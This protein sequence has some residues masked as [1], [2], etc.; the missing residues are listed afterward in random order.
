MLASAYWLLSAAGLVTIL[1]QAG[2]TLVLW[3]FAG[4]RVS[5]PGAHIRIRPT[6]NFNVGLLRNPYLL[7][8]LWCVALAGILLLLRSE[9]FLQRKVARIGAGVALG[10]AS[11][12]LL[13]RLKA[14]GVLDYI[15]LG[16]WRIFNPADVAI[17]AGAV[18]AICFIS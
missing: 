7:L 5:T 6:T 10:G 9:I 1:D 8:G 14:E 17:I 12:N 11:S 2:K 15:D 16:F 13:D 18:T 3:R 4:G